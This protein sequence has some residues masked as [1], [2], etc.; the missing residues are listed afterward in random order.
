MPN[1]ASL[2]I[3]IRW[4]PGLPKV[5]PT[6][7]AA[8][9]SGPRAPGDRE[10]IGVEWRPLRASYVLLNS[11]GKDHGQP[12][13]HRH[14]PSPPRASAGIKRAAY[15]GRKAGSQILPYPD[16]V[17]RPESSISTT[18]QDWLQWYRRCFQAGTLASP[19]PRRS[20]KGTLSIGARTWKPCRRSRLK[21]ARGPAA[22]IVFMARRTAPHQY[23][24]AMENR[25]GRWSSTGGVWYRNKSS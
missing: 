16:P 15:A 19:E 8:A 10:K 11:T 22:R 23:Y 5:R 20:N 18:P 9:S 24:Y 4:P 25:P 3:G 1:S 12:P 2:C 6:P 13:K 7:E 21:P 17:I 14:I